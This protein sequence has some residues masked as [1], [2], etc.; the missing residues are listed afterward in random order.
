[1]NKIDDNQK[2]KSII[3]NYS[4]LQSASSQKTLLNNYLKTNKSEE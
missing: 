2:L 1:M 3:S 4:K